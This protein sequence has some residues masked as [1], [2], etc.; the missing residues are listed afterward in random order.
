MTHR[1][2]VRIYYEDTDFSG[3]VYHANYLRY[4]ERGRTE[5]LRDAGFAHR[6]LLEADPP[7]VFTVRTVSIDYQKPARIDELLMVETDLTAITG[8]RM[9]FTQR[10]L[11]NDELLATAEVTV[12][13]MDLAGKPKRLPAPVKDALEAL[14][15]E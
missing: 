12:A 11:R 9:V 15:A 1:L 7:R 5:A 2:D 13:C 3:V 8:A 10:L 14:I 4:F 6:A